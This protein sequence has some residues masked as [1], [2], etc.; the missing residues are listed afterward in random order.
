MGEC[1][2]AALQEF[3]E[4]PNVGGVGR[5]RKARQALLNFQVVEKS[6]DDPRIGFRRHTGSMRII[7]HPSK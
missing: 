1:P 6:R 2:L 3:R 4:L 5:N 7:G